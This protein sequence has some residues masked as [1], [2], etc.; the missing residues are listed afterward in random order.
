M[1]NRSQVDFGVNGAIGTIVTKWDLILF[2]QWIVLI[3]TIICFLYTHH[4]PLKCSPHKP[5]YNYIF[6]SPNTNQRK[7]QHSYNTPKSQ[8]TNSANPVVRGWLPCT[9]LWYVIGQPIG[10]PIGQSLGQLLTSLHGPHRT[11]PSTKN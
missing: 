6:I 2:G 7:P 5:L 9:N 10:Q 4:M 11:Q 1:L 3:H 8:P